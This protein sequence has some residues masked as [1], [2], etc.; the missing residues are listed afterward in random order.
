MRVTFTTT[1][2]QKNN[3]NDNMTRIDLGECEILLRKYYNLTNNETLYMKKLEVIQKGMK[4]PKV[5]YDIYCKLLG[6]NLIK[7][8]LSVCKN[9]KISLVVP[10]EI[11]DNL[12]KLNSNSE[13]YNDLC[14]TTTSE[15][16]TDIILKDRKNEYINKT[17]CQD[18][19]EFSD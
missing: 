6:S 12:D 13:Y 11:T 1:Q 10:V 15:S 14:Y 7:L 9:S 19:C 5:E 4:I 8:N 16:G 3:I 2:N 17:V 18:D